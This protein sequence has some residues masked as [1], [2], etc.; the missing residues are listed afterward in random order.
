[1]LFPRFIVKRSFPGRLG[2]RRASRNALISF[3]MRRSSRR[4]I[5]FRH[6][7]PILGRQVLHLSLTVNR[8]SYESDAR[9]TCG[10]LNSTLRRGGKYMPLLFFGV[11]ELF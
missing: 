7:F 9:S 3:F 1:M 8:L 11:E 10:P 4:N 2:D 5:V 6:S